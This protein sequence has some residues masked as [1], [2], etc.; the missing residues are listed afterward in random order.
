MSDQA[1]IAFEAEVDDKGRI[2]PQGAQVIRARLAKW[3]GRKVLVTVARFVKNKTLPQ[4]GYYFDVI[5]P[6]WA[7][8]AGYD[9]DEMHTELKR[10]YFP[11]RREVSKLTGEECDE[12]PSLADATASEMSTFLDRVLREAA[13]Q[14]LYIP[15]ANKNWEYEKVAL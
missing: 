4:L 12:L 5:V 8:H 14:S 15:P 6:I 1:R 9:E 7:D 3:K 13:H 2:H 11:K 10:A